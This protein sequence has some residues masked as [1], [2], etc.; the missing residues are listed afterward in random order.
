M[1]CSSVCFCRNE[2]YKAAH[3]EGKI[4]GPT[5]SKGPLKDGGEASSFLTSG[6]F[7]HYN[8]E[9]K[10]VG[11]QEYVTHVARTGKLEYIDAI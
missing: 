4:T 7:A 10:C 6:M 5:A 2:F 11:L 9:K 8:T 1:D 3:S